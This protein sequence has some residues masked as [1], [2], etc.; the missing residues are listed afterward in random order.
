MD[1]GE[2]VYSE[3]YLDDLQEEDGI[4]AE[5]SGFMRGYLQD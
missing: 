4:S 2:T 1:E 5:E 3:E